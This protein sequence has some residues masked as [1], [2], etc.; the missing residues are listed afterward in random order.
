[1]ADT[2][3]VWIPV[4]INPDN[5]NPDEPGTDLTVGQEVFVSTTKEQGRGALDAAAAADV[6]AVSARVNGKADADLGNVDDD[7]FSAKV[8]AGLGY[9]PADDALANVG[10][11]DFAG[12]AF[13]AAGGTAERSLS[14]RFGEDTTPM[15][16]GAVGDAAAD[17]AAELLACQTAAA[18]SGYALRLR[19]QH[20]I[21]SDITITRPLIVEAGGG[22]VIDAGVTVTINAPVF[23]KEHQAFFGSGSVAGTFGQR[24]ARPWW[25]GVS[26]DPTHVSAANDTAILAAVNACAAAGLVLNGGGKRIQ[27]N[28]VKT[29]STPGEYVWRELEWYKASTSGALETLWTFTGPTYDQ[30]LELAANSSLRSRT[31]SVGSGVGA[32][33]QLNQ[34]YLLVSTKVYSYDGSSNLHVSEWVTPTGVAGDVVTLAENLKSSYAT[35]D[36]A[37]LLHY[38]Q[39][40]IVDFEKVGAVGSGDGQI[41]RAFQ[42]N[43]CMIQRFKNCWSQDCV[44]TAVAMTMCWFSGEVDG[45][46]GDNVDYPGIGYV[47]AMGG[48]DEPKVGHVHGKRARH[49]VTIGGGGGNVTWTAGGG[50]RSATVMGRGGYCRSVH[51][52][53]ATSSVF[54]QHHGHVGLTG[55]RV[56]GNLSGQGSS[57]PAVTLQAPDIVMG[58]INV[59]GGGTNLLLIQYFGRPSDE[60]PPSFTLGAC[61]DGGTTPSG[62]YVGLIENKDSTNRATVYVNMRS[63]RGVGGGGLLLD[64][65]EGD[66]RF[67]ADDLHL[68]AENSTL[69]GLYANAYANGRVFAD[70]GHAYIEDATLSASR[71]AV[72]A[73]GGVYTAAHAG[74]L[75]AFVRIRSG[76]IIKSG[77]VAASATLR[78]LDGIIELGADVEVSGATSFKTTASS[79][80]GTSDVYRTSR[81]V[82]AA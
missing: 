40:L 47:L 34:R 74:T 67:L 57:A 19:R 33:V 46:Y 44:Y 69:Y 37:T 9:T 49:T 52:D 3:A 5:W 23:S 77:G 28:S 25:W 73:R 12:K 11:S 36:Y 45:L 78:A 26:I 80:V 18:V 4:S 41:Q 7:V 81:A 79:T 2:P 22:L 58:D 66:I 31:V 64:A 68:K 75:G 42:L 61:Q 70:I 65:E 1:M 48:C 29:I 27:L 39:T 15:D 24:P 10:A 76:K 21:A 16:F 56:S 53:E 54:D 8:M 32:S 72:Y 20:R 38:P 71:Y 59:T 82:A 6:E 35:A 50:S 60:P 43:R 30:T 51:C 55:P 63:L 17:D 62:Q 13:Q 14:A